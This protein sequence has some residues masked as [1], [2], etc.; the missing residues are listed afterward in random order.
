MLIK[1]LKWT[2]ALL[3]QTSSCFLCCLD[4][5]IPLAAGVGEARYN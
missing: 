5:V 2:R 4:L 1:K 3:T